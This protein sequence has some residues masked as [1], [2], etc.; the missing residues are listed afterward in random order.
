VAVKSDKWIRKMA[1]EHQMIEPFS[2]KQVREG[3]ISYGL[4][5]YGYDVR[6]A[7]EFKIFT[8]INHM[9]VDP[10]DF[11]PRSFV[12]LAGEECIIP[13]NSFA[14]ART[15][16][17]FKVPRDVIVVCLGKCLSGD[18]GVVDG[19]TGRLVPIASYLGR[20]GSAA[21]LRRQAVGSEHVSEGT[22]QGILPVYELKT[23]TGRSI[24]A[25]PNHPFLT[26]AGWRPLHGLAV[27]SRI[28]VPRRLA[29][30]GRREM[31]P[32][33]I[34]LLGLLISDGCCRTPGSSPAYT[35]GDPVLREAFSAAVKSFGCVPRP[36]RTMTVRATNRGCRG[37]RMEPNRLYRWLESLGLNVNSP[38]KSVPPPV[39]E[40]RRPQ[41]ARFLRA[42]FSGDGGISVGGDT[43]HLEFCSTSAQLA[44]EVQHLLLRFGVV[45]RKRWRPTVSGRGAYTLSI[46]SKEHVKRFAE[47]I[48]FIVGSRKQRR[49][50]EAMELIELRPQKK[51][52]Y[53]TLPREA[54]KLMDDLCR[55]RGTSLRSMGLAWP[56]FKQSVPRAFA[57]DI[58]RR[59]GDEMLGVIADG[60]VLWDV[61]AE[62]RFAGF[63]PVFDLTVPETS[64][65][66]ANDMIVHNSTYARCG[67]IVN[68]T[69][70]EPEWEGIVTLEV[71]N[72]TPLPA[73]IY[74]GEGIAQMLFFQSDEACETSYA[75]KKGKYQSQDGLTLP[76][77]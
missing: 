69:P 43:V 39:F 63:E 46:T 4:S 17:R 19:D 52:N 21:S 73:R 58:A 47:E 10:K 24:R 49:L 59:L 65:F 12:D 15:V 37:G 55:E 61:V 75:D 9:V 30:F 25:T 40:L 32:W 56:S 74:A 44:G 38:E 70:L 48:G 50:D 60:D 72:T 66:L 23:R 18:T 51:S 3:V 36:S 33:E 45:A 42:L 13:P 2:E 35:S 41:L 11:D 26:F 71:S 53:D 68:V 22:K 34:D 54:W 8:N 67:I 77:L 20:S 29:V 27:G 64:N 1:L 31:P 28:A 16:E 14:L 57:S 5:S 62:K 7:D 6:I 76:R